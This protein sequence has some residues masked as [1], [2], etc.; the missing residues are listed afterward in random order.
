MTRTC[1]QEVVHDDSYFTG[2]ND[3]TKVAKI[4]DDDSDSRGNGCQ[5][6]HTILA[7]PISDVA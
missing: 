2:K 1:H 5:N 4:K 3:A 6:P 7:R